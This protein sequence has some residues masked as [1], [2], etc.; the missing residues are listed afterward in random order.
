LKNTGKLHQSSSNLQPDHMDKI[1][2]GQ[3]QHALV[4]GGSISGLLTAR[5]L[6]NHFKKVTIIEKDPV[7]RYPESRKG[8][9]QTRHLHGL[10]PTGLNILTHYFPNLAE[11]I[12]N[13]GANVVDF[14]SS[15]HWYAYGGFKKPFQLGIKGVSVSRP[16]LEH[17]VRERVLS[18]PNVVLLDQTEAKQLISANGYGKTTGIIAENKGTGDN[19]SIASDLVVDATGRGSRAPQWLKAM[20]YGETTT[21]EVKIDVAYMT[22]IYKRDPDDPRG[23]KWIIFTPQA[24]KET[25]FGGAFPIEG[26]RWVVTV[27]GWHGDH[28]PFEEEN[29]FRFVKSLPN[30]DIYDIVRNSA[31]LSELMQYKFPLS[32]RRHFEQLNR[33]PSGFIVLGDAISSFNPIYGQGMTSACMQAVELDKLL[34]DNLPPEKLAAAYFKNTAR[35][36]DNIWKLATFEDFRFPQTTGRRP[37]GI[38]LLNN[39]IAQVHRATIKDEVVGAALLKVMS[40][41]KPATILFHPRIL[42]R[43]LR[44]K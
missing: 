14:A 2:S 16:L 43:V 33:F 30:P 11:E 32:I 1:H 18:L 44:P 5:V 28:A 40:L 22:R 7:H 39:Y 20:D 25:R 13:N 37:F 24:P 10:L 21:T 26:N 31:P 17:L 23:K 35:I 42:W 8:Q 29:Y 12:E 9:P 4:L 15:M 6:S 3:R 38:N 19:S 34:Q 41:L 27:G 36:I